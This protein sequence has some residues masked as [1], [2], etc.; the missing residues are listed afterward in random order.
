MNWRVFRGK[1]TEL[2]TALC[3]KMFTGHLQSE[4]SGC[5]RG[6]VKC[7]LRVPQAT[8]LYCSCHVAQASKGFF[9]KT[10]HK[11]FRT[12]CRPRLYCSLYLVSTVYYQ[13]IWSYIT[14]LIGYYDYLG[15]RPKNSHR[16]IIV[17]G[18]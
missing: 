10:H 11:T 7:F 4:A 18:R 14:V 16:L 12:T 13:C 9:G 1:W 8:L 17:T 2:Y 6:S 15:T 5:E 3:R